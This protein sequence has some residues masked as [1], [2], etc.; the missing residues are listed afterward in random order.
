MDIPQLLQGVAGLAWPLITGVVLWK[1]FPLV[2]EI[3]SSRAFTIKV[4]SMELSVQEATEQLRANIEDLQ[5]KVE[6]LRAQPREGLVA[7][8]SPTLPAPS[9][10][11]RIVWVDDSPANNALEIARL[12][13]EGVEVI[14]VTSTQEALRVLLAE[15][16]PVRAVISDMARR[17]SGQLNWRAGIELI[18][19]LRQAG[20][21][22]PVFVYG[23]ERALVSTRD[24]VRTVGGNGATTSSIELFELL[25]GVLGKTA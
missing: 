19:Q 20:L 10:P 12:H 15:R 13:D 7:S 21:S 9:A 24:E 23:S 8:E 11:R 14:P 2:R 6:E 25:R 17:E 1:L 16:M 5:K 22:V 3:T 4:G 18:Q